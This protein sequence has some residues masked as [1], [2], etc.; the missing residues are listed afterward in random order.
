MA[1]FIGVM[2]LATAAFPRQMSAWRMRG[3][4]GDT[5][6]EPSRGRLLMMRVT[7]VVVAAVAGVMALGDPGMLV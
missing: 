4:G 6:I 5:R 2:D 3:P 1:L 7:G